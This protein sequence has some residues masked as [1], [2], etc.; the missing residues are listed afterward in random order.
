MEQKKVRV[1]KIVGCHGVRG[2]V[3]LRPSSEEADWAM[4][5]VTVYLKDKVGLER[6]LTIQNI[7]QQGPLL[8]L[9]FKELENRT[10]AEPFVGSA[11]FAAVADLKPPKEGEYWVDDLIG[12]SVLDAETSRVRG[13]V[14]D[15]LSSGGT[16]FL[17][18]QL[19]GSTETA[20]IPFNEHFFP[21]VDIE[22][23]TITVDLLSDFLD[24]KPVSDSH[25]EQ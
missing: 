1:G 2:D 18:I 22:N 11:L 12:L 7:R 20:V 14:K 17:E 24:P 3:K 13:K 21:T 23:K 16:D 8:I 15:I 5:G 6:P 19:E 4:A 25:L 9:H 10:Q